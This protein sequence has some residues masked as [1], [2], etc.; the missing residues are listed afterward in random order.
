MVTY[1]IQDRD[2]KT[3]PARM[4]RAADAGEAC[5]IMNWIQPGRDWS[6]IRHP[7]E[8]GVRLS[9]QARD[10]YRDGDEMKV[11]LRNHQEAKAQVKAL[12]DVLEDNGF[13]D[14]AD[15]LRSLW[16]AYERDG[17]LF[18]SDLL[19]AVRDARETLNQF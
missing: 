12:A 1:F 6:V 19:G 3:L 8:D 2:G 17:S 15:E 16:L 7:C 18:A 5:A 9:L 13:Q 14:D 4:V 11:D 10:T